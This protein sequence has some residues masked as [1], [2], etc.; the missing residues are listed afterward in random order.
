[1]LKLGMKV[2]LEDQVGRVVGRTIEYQPK[3]DVMLANGTIRSYV[4]E[5]D[6]VVA[7]QSDGKADA[8]A[9]IGV[10]PTAVGGGLDMAAR[11]SISV[12]R[13]DAN[14]EELDADPDRGG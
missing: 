12:Q 2:G 1:M 9:E 10:V 6:L 4:R 13:N 11:S 5:V 7:P 3:Y 14:E 8:G